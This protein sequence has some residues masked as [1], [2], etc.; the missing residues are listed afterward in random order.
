MTDPIADMLTRIRN[1]NQAFHERVEIPASKVKVN[2]ARV[3]HEEGFIRS[4]RIVEDQKQGIIRIYLK[5][6]D[7][8]ERVISGIDRISKRGRRVYAT[9][10]TL[11]RV[12]GGLGLAILSTSMGVMTDKA[13][14]KANIG[15][16]VLCRV[17]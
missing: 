15:G 7:T 6:S 5:Y 14:R 16:E 10:S 1:S 2:I 8:E 11:P 3:L 17:W 12:F 4:Y 13:C 9:K